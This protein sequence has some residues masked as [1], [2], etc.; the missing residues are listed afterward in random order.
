[1]P[2]PGA[3]LQPGGLVAGFPSGRSAGVSLG[4]DEERGS[5]G[6]VLDRWG[7]RGTEEIGFSDTVLPR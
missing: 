6:R 5:G 3:L 2:P 1:M 7:D 4:G